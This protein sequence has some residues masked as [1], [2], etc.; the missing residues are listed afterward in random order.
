MIAA[1]LSCAWRS[2]VE[3]FLLEALEFGG[4]EGG[5]QHH[6]G[7]QRQGLVEVAG[8]GGEATAL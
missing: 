4:G 7:Q 5:P 3:A 2:A 8:R 6:I 1:G